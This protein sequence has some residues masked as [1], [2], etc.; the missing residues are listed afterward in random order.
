MKINRALREYFSGSAMSQNDFLSLFV[1]SPFFKSVMKDIVSVYGKLNEHFKSY[2]KQEIRDIPESETFK[3]DLKSTYE[4]WMLMLTENPPYF[5][6][7][8]KIVL[9]SPSALSR[10]L[11]VY[12]RYQLEYLDLNDKRNKGKRFEKVEGDIFLADF[13]RI[14]MFDFHDFYDQ[15]KI[16][17]LADYYDQ[18]LIGDVVTKIHGFIDHDNIHVALRIGV[19]DFPEIIGEPSKRE[20]PIHHSKMGHLFDFDE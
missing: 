5:E 7:V 8:I 17:L 4:D 20:K 1:E 10:F 19:L 11:E 12:L 6:R 16:F 3:A 18:N 14:R 2:L 13:G 15:A 9:I